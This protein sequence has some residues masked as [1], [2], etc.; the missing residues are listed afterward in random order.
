MEIERT[1]Q[2]WSIGSSRVKWSAISAGWAVGLAT[3][4]MLTLLGLAI[5]AWSVDLREAQSTEGIP[6]GTGVWT[7]ISML[8]SAFVGGFVTARLSGS[9]LRA[10]GLYHGI[11]VWGVNWLIFAWLTTTAMAYLVGGLFTALGTTV[12]AMSSGIGDVTSAAMAQAPGGISIS[13]DELKKQV[14]SVLQS[15]GKRELQPG[16]MKQD[17]DRLKS[18]VK[19][20]QSAEQITN[21]AL[22]ELQQK[23]T[24]L[25]RDAAISVM[26]NKLGMSEA[27]ARQLVQATIGIAGPLKQKA[28]EVKE[29]SVEK[30]TTAINRVG[31]IAMWLFV[32]ALVTLGLSAGGGMVGTAKEGAL[33]THGTSYTTDVRK[34][35]PRPATI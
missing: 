3:Q 8:I 14:E 1:L 25:D 15:T 34:G 26:V 20:G 10:D 23:L 21:A 6:L 28:Q 12:Q 9:Y 13:T 19:S 24:S 35:M 7:G 2:Q 11:V 5:G 31:T 16:E 17:A 33:E 27:Q 29:H 30:G 22:T 32:L 4:M 18:D